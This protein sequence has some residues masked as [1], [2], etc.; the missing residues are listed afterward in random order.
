MPPGQPQIQAP[1]AAER[2]LPLFPEHTLS[3]ITDPT[4]PHPES[5]RK[6]LQPPLPTLAQV[7]ATWDH[8][9]K[10]VARRRRI[11]ETILS[12][13]RPL[14]L[15]GKQVVLGFSPQ[16]RFQQELIQSDDYRHLIE[17]ELRKAFGGELEVTTELYP[18]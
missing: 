15:V 10:R 12:T 7:N 2:G 9:V 3:F 18:V 8:I 4:P 5:Q 14:R 6:D 11:L 16:Q 1:P 17:E 13:A